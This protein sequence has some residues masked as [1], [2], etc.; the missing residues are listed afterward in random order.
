[1]VVILRS[2]LQFISFRGL[3]LNVPVF[4]CHPIFN[5]CPAANY[6]QEGR[7]NLPLGCFFRS[8][9]ATIVPTNLF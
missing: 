3:D 1:M 4:P 2:K 7:V 5:L 8:V 9:S 6:A